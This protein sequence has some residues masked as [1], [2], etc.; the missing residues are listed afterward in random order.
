V[1]CGA[2]HD[3][4]PVHELARTLGWDV[5]VV[6]FRPA[7]ASAARFPGATTHVLAP[8]QLERLPLE[9]GCAVVIMSHHLVYDGRLV[10][11]VLR[12]PLPA[13]VGLLG[14]SKRTADLRAM[15]PKDLPFERLHAPVG[16]ALGGEGPPAVALAVL[17]EVHAA[18][19]GASARPMSSGSQLRADCVT[20]ARRESRSAPCRVLAVRRKC[21]ATR[22]QTRALVSLSRC[23]RR[24]RGPPA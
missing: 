5:H 18:L 8:D 16:L 14:P 11:A 4:R 20:E 12:S 22:C 21:W 9:A 7:Q 10:E 1:V 2:G 23:L 6:D 19:H 3:A 24:R 15:L 13:Y 17:A